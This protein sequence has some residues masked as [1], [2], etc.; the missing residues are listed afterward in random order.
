MSPLRLPRFVAVGILALLACE[1]NPPPQLPPTP[2]PVVVAPPAEDEAAVRKEAASWRASRLFIDLHEHVDTTPEHLARAVRIQDAV[3]IGLAVNLSGGYVTRQGGRGQSEFQAGKALTDRLYPGRFVQ[4]MN[5][6]YSDWDRPDFADPRGRAGRGGGTPR[7]PPGSRS[8]SGSGCISAT[9]RV[10]SSRSTIRSSTSC[11]SGSASSG[12]PS[13]STSPTPSAFWLPFDES[14][15][16]W[17]ELKDHPN[18][19]FGDP[20]EVPPARGAPC[21]A[22]ARHRAPPGDH[23]RLRCTS[24]TT[25]RTW[26]GST[27]SSDATRT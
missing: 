15:E 18:W 11:G 17:E 10:S 1:A 14:N 7:A 21:R 20:A 9:G 2:P 8:S 19:W 27:R 23:V 26:R 16:R 4:Y 25:P 3:G 24:A 5:L 6:D 22:R 13:P 12:C